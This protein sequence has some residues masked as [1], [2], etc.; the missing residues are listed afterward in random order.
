MEG[1]AVGGAVAEEHHGDLVVL[2]DHLV[3]QGGTGGQVVAA[4][5]D[6]VGAQHAHGEVSNVHGAAAALAQAGLLAV[7]LSHHAVHIGALGHA[8]TMAAVSGLDHVILPQGGAHAGGNGFLADVQVDKARDLTRQE[9]VLDGLLE[10][11]DGAHSLVE[12]GRLF[13]GVLFSLRFRCCHRKELPSADLIGVFNLYCGM[14]PAFCG[15]YW[16]FLNFDSKKRG[17]SRLQP[18]FFDSAQSAN[19]GAVA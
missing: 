8:V 2:Q 5:H 10:L 9:I 15:K 14:F 17:D 18:R 4:A 7:D 12:L 19:A 3:G 13:L 11:A 1:T 16:L 6:A